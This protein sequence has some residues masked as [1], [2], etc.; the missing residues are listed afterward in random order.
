M[1]QVVDEANEISHKIV[2]STRIALKGM[3]NILNGILRRDANGQYDMLINMTKF[4]GKDASIVGA[5]GAPRGG[6]ASSFL[7]N[8]IDALQK[9]QNTSQI[10]NEIDAIERNN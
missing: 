10:L 9:F 4:L 8:I 1:Q 7:N 3:I 6:K 5:D 2:D